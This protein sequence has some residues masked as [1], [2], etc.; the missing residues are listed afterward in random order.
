MKST[1]FISIMPCNRQ[2]YTQR[3]Y[4]K[5]MKK[6]GVIPRDCS[7]SQHKSWL[8]VL[9]EKVLSGASRVSSVIE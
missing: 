8:S 7:T 4:P 9:M 6:T 2:T 3:A 1:F 5:K